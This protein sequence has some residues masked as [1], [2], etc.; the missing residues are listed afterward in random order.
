MKK[1]MF[2]CAVFFVAISF[3]QAKIATLEDGT[4]IVLKEDKTWGSV[5]ANNR[6]SCVVKEGF[7]EPKWISTKIRTRNKTSVRD[8][9]KYVVA[10]TGVDVSK[11][12]LL[13][14]EDTAS[15]GLY[16]LCVD[17]QEKRYIRRGSV[18]EKK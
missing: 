8:L 17:G 9:K 5:A 16:V 1:V 6:V 2:I 14:F 15:N 4:K 13:S 10:D 12:I 18:F 7:K 11:V 3:S